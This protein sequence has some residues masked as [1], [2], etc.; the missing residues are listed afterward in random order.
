MS[1]AASRKEYKVLYIDVSRAYFYAKSVR[2]TYIKL[3]AEDPGANE[4]WRGSQRCSRSNYVKRSLEDFEI[5][6]GPEA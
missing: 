2:P 5:V 6:F 3:P 4:L 1:K